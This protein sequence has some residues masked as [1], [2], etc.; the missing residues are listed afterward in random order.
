MEPDREQNR[1]RPG[2]AGFALAVSER[3]FFRCKTRKVTEKPEANPVFHPGTAD[4][5]SRLAVLLFLLFFTLLAGTSGEFGPFSIRFD[6]GWGWPGRAA[7]L[8]PCWARLKPIPTAGRSSFPC[9]WRRSIPPPPAR[10]G[11]LCQPPGIPGRVAPPACGGSSIFSLAKLAILGGVARSLV[12]LVFGRRDLHRLWRAAAAGSLGVLLLLGGVALDY[13]R[14]AFKN[15][16]MKGCWPSPPG[17]CTWLTRAWRT[18][19]NWARGSPW[20]PEIWTAWSRRWIF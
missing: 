17:S 11:G 12:A 2:G 8:S 18:C 14:E 4:R 7:W 20:W 19:R 1:R 13:D 9:G 10:T 6:L 3:G 5:P 15:P 16:V